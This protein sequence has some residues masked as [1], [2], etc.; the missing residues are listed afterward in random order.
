MTNIQVTCQA[1]TAYIH[2]QVQK[3]FSDY[4]K[5]LVKI[6]NSSKDAPDYIYFTMHGTAT[7]TPVQGYL[8]VYGVKDWSD[9]V[10]PRVYD[11]FDN[12][13]FKYNETNDTMGINLDLDVQNHRI[14]GYP[15]NKPNTY[16]EDQLL[17]RKHIFSLTRD[18]IVGG[19]F[20]PESTLC[21]FKIEEFTYQT[22]TH[23]YFRALF[24]F[25]EARLRDRRVAITFRHKN[26]QKFSFYSNIYRQ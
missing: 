5:V 13:M 18:T 7:A 24:L 12:T 21:Y 1:I 11:G 10:D 16:E 26:G 8:I 3:D 4:S 9:S 17:S 25:P 23:Y 15:I 19:Q 20:Y 2:S 22:S 6:N 14:T